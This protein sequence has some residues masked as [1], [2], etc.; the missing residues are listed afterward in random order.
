T[1]WYWGG[2]TVA[3]LKN[4]PLISAFL[5]AGQADG[6]TPSIRV[7]LPSLPQSR[8]ALQIRLRFDG[9]QS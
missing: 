5:L 4:Q 7:R 6:A 9:Q 1:T 3:F 8:T 2:S